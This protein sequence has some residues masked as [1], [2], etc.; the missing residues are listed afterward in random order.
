MTYD[1]FTQTMQRKGKAEE[2]VYFARLDRKLIEQLRQQ[3][4][5]PR[6]EPLAS[7]SQ[8]PAVTPSSI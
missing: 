1:H 8:Q 7:L 4:A 6:K 3:K 5:S 2:D